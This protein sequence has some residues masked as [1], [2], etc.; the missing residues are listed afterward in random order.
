[1]KHREMQME[2]FKFSGGDSRVRKSL[3][4]KDPTVGELTVSSDEGIVLALLL[5]EIR[6]LRRA[7]ENQPSR[8]NS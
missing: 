2:G 4:F 6:L 7:I 8:E 1:M 3:T 5:G